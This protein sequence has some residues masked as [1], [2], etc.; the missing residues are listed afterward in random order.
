MQ[1]LFACILNGCLHRVLKA[2]VLPYHLCVTGYQL[3][4]YHQ[5]EC[6]AVDCKRQSSYR[7]FQSAEPLEVPQTVQ[8]ELTVTTAGGYATCGTGIQQ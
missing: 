7:R 6:I 5:S 4:P 8:R 2:P 3:C 1:L